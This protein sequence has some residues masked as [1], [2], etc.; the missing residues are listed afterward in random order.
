M[1]TNESQATAENIESDR[2]FGERSTQAAS[3]TA[4]EEQGVEVP[5]QDGREP[6]TEEEME[7]RDSQFADGDDDGA[8]G[9]P[10]MPSPP[11][12]EVANREPSESTPNEAEDQEANDESQEESAELAQ[13]EA[14]E[15]VDSPPEATAE[16]R[17][18]LAKVEAREL[19]SLE[20]SIPQPK[21][22]EQPEPENEVGEEE[23]IPEPQ[24]EE[25]EQAVAQEESSAPSASGEQGTENGFEREASKTKISGTIRR[26]GESSVDVEDTVKGRFLASVNQQIEKAWQRECIMRREH[27]LPGV[28]SVSFVINDKGKVTGFRFDSRIAGGAIQEGFTMLAVQKAELPEMPPEMTKELNGNTLEMSLTFFF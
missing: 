12:E 26:V 5:T 16:E 27:I 8:P 23:A 14:G 28:L 24:E 21:E 10:G 20:E 13:A 19:L 1:P 11:S 2:Y 25:L 4:G 3:E 7:L 15:E 6:R 9:S 17:L 22:E 18:D